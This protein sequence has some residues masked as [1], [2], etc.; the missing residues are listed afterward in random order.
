MDVFLIGHDYK[1]EIAEFLK[2]FSSE[3]SFK[4][5]SEELS[6]LGIGKNSI[7]DCSED[8]KDEIDLFIEKYIGEDLDKIIILNFLNSSTDNRNVYVK[9]KSII[10]RGLNR[11]YENTL[12]EIIKLSS[13][14]VGDTDEMFDKSIESKIKTVSKRL[15]QKTMFPYLKENFDVNLPWGILTG[16][17]PVKLIHSLMDNDKTDDEIREFMIN[18]YLISDEKLDLILDIAK[19]ERRFIY[20]LS[21]DKISLYISVPFCPTRCLYCSFPSHPLKKY[22]DLRDE[23]VEKLLIEARGLNEIILKQGKEIESLYIGGGTPTALEAEQLKKLI[24]GVFEIFDLTKIKEFTV[25]AGRPDS[26]TKEKLQALKDSG[27]DRISINPQ[28]FKDE[29]LS[30]VGRNHSSNDIITCFNMARELGFDNINMDIILGLPKETPEDVEETLKKIVELDPESVTIHTL[31]LKRASDLKMNMDEYK[32]ELTGYES[33]IKMLDLSSK[34]MKNNGYNPYYMYRQKHMLGNLENVGYAKEGYE[35][36]YNMQIM[37]EKQSNYAIGAGAVSKFVYL[38]EN[39]IERVD[40][41]KNVEIYIQRVEDMID[42]KIRE[43]EKNDKSSKR[44]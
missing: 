10:Y 19:R 28:T 5:I 2:L 11:V 24:Q 30:I 31:A 32:R 14:E 16:I 22:K 33:M 38:D 6:Y 29:T 17:R 7:I 37:E 25:E 8:Y 20:P 34:Y 23:Y 44:N 43:V 4:E 12:E 3:F 9:S 13:N 15:I 18:N 27:V 21:K 42:K 26:I 39:R 40:D 41:V 1:Y 35:C 36:L